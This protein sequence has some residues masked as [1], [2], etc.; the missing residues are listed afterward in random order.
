MSKRDR[1]SEIMRAAEKLFTSSR[2][3]EVAVD[4][5]C[6]EAGVGK[7]TVYRYF[8]DKDDLFFQTA[9]SGFEELCRVLEG[10][11]SGGA[12]FREQLVSACREISDFFRRRKSLFRMMQGEEWRM[13]GRK[14]E[15][16]RQWRAS[17]DKM[18]SAL[19]GLLAQGTAEG[20]LRSDLSSEVLAAFLLGMLRTG[21]REPELAAHAE[22]DSLCV[23]LFLEGAGANRVAGI[24]AV[25]GHPGEQS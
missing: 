2:F 18:V 9:M 4:D 10:S 19:A 24:S 17:R 22:A 5:V 20:I 23:D 1:R 3:H 8:R 6:R 7:G 14:R 21:A 15:L 11:A 25:S 16:R 13:Q 12:D